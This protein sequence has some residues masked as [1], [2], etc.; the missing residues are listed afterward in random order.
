MQI[1]CTASIA[2]TPP[3]IKCGCM[4]AVDFVCNCNCKQVAQAL[5][6]ASHHSLCKRP[7]RLMLP[8]RLVGQ[9]LFCG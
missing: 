6:S 7:A 9:S 2:S 4:S 1:L 8:A 3:C 5:E